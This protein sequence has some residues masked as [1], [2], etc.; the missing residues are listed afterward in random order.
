MLCFY[1]YP[2]SLKN[3]QNRQESRF[4]NRAHFLPTCARAEIIIERSAAARGPVRAAGDKRDGARGVDERTSMAP[5]KSD[6]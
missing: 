6:A 4:Q 3:Q 5:G 2:N 1:L